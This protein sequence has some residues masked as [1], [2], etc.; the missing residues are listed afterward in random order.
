MAN[1][2]YKLELKDLKE[3]WENDEITIELLGEKMAERLR[4]LSKIM[5][6][7]DITKKNYV[8]IDM[9]LP[10]LQLM[11]LEGIIDE[12]EIKRIKVK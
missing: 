10:F 4:N 2:K 9:I 11:E 3:K 8:Y 5:K 6:A 12:H 7:D 1:W